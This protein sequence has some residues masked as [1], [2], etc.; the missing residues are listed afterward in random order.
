[1]E[2]REGNLGE[3][4][5]AAAPKRGPGRPVRLSPSVMADE[6]EADERE[7]QERDFTQDRDLTDADRLQMFRDSLHQSIL[8]DLPHFPGYHVCWL[9]TSNPRDTIAN[10]RRLGYELIRVEECPTFQD[11]GSTVQGFD[12][13]VTV[14]EMIAAKIPLRL[15]N[16]Y[17]RTSHH[18]APLDEEEKLRAQVESIKEGLASQGSRVVEIGGGTDAVVQKAPLQPDF[19]P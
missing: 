12:G 9:T 15:Y 4:Q 8:P 16:A 17:M 2:H 5:E 14:N 6:R 19:G 3:G 18:E 13:F 7:A 11:V 1:M 10:R